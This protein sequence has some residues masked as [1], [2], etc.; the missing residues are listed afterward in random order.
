MMRI[1]AIAGAEALLRR[2]QHRWLSSETQ[3]VKSRTPEQSDYRVVRRAPGGWLLL[4]AATVVGSIA[5]YYFNNEYEKKSE[6]LKTPR[7]FGKASIGGPFTLVNTEG[8]V[9]TDETYKGKFTLIY[10]G[11]TFCPDICPDELEKISA[12]IDALDETEQN[13]LQPLLISVDPYRDNPKRVKEYL[14]DFHPKFEGLTGDEDEVERVAKAYRVYFSKADVTD[15][16]D[17]YLVDHSIITYLMAP[18]GSFCEFFGK[19]AT[20][21]EITKRI[22]NQI[23]NYTMTVLKSQAIK[24]ASAAKQS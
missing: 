22:R 18:D 21:D 6:K 14:R 2:S 7:T 24:E 11:F 19:S 9:V 1:R 4:G 12:A 3:G 5:A 23:T 8:K 10:F 17:D 15:V 13:I 20:A 16:G